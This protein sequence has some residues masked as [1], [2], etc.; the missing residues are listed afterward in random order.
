MMA[1]RRRTAGVLLVALLVGLGGFLLLGGDDES[2]F[3]PASKRDQVSES[4]SGEG[5]EEPNA[6][7]QENAEAAGPQPGD[8]DFPVKHIVF[9]IK[10]NRSFDNY[11]ARYPGA[12][13]A[14][15][16]KT[17]TGETVRLS[18]AT[19]VMT[20]DIGHD[21]PAG[22]YAINGGKMD[23]FD[24]VANG[25][26][27]SGYS[28]FKRRGIPNYWAYAD[29]FVL[30][31]RMF[32]SMYGPTFPAHLYTVAAQSGWVTGNKNETGGEGGY[33][34]DAEEYVW[35]FSKLSPKERRTVM[36]A[37]ERGDFDTVGDYWEEIRACLDFKVLPDVLEK[38]GISWHYYA[39][40]GSWMNAM[41]AIKHMRFSKHWGTDITPEEQF[42]PD[43]ENERL[44][45]VTWVVPGPGVNEHPGGPSVCVGEN[46]TVDVVNRIMRS[47]YWKSTAIFLTW[48]DFGGFYDHVPPPHPDVMGFGPR[49]PLLIISPWAKEGYID[50]TTYEFSSV[51]KFIETVHGLKPLTERDAAADDMMGAFDFSSET[52]PRDRKLILEERSCEGLPVSTVKEYENHGILNAFEWLGD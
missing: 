20:P 48:D 16:G 37:E 50:S 5:S 22:V 33:C 18:E 44:D 42:I 19:D 32:T 21:F 28:S 26:N 46:W 3:D 40:E 29:E 2:R 6:E 41:L 1:R 23:G 9:I 25:E 52:K 15:H 30:G 34:D 47:K 45:E 13:G 8:P 17:S 11:F 51:L 27:L 24:L 49:A 35:R 4:P 14:T 12:D 10:E 7:D 39:D 31:D 43:V 36:R 38:K